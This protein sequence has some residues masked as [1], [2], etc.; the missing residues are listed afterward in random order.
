MERDVK[1]KSHLRSDIG[2]M[3]MKLMVGTDWLTLGVEE[4]KRCDPDNL[5]NV[6][7]NALAWPAR[8]STR[9]CSKHTFLKPM[10]YR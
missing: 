1:A 2:N 3:I 8:V 4:K 5:G 7:S 9:Q 6:N 10:G